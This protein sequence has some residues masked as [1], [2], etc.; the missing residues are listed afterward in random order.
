MCCFDT[1]P[2]HPQLKVQPTTLLLK[3]IKS[4]SEHSFLT[5][6]AGSVYPGLHK[7]HAVTTARVTCTPKALD[8]HKNSCMVLIPLSKNNLNLPKCSFFISAVLGCLFLLFI[9]LLCLLTRCTDFLV[10]LFL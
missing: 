5:L 9:V 6:C 2:Y 10:C 1:P 4:I 3:F 8:V 7:L